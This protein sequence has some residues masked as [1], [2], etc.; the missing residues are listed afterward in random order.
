[1]PLEELP[2]YVNDVISIKKKTKIRVKL[3]LE[4]DF[5][6]DDMS[7]FNILKHYAFDYFI[8]SVHFIGEWGFDQ[9]DY[10]SEFGRMGVDKAYIKYCELIGRM[11]D[12]CLFDIVGHLDLPKKFGHFPGKKVLPHFDRA[13]R[14]VKSANMAVE[15]NTSGL[16]RKAKEMYPSPDILKL[17]YQHDIP[18]TLGSDSH[19]PGEV[20]R[21]F[22]EAKALLRKVGYHSLVSFTNHRHTKFRIS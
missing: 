11:A 9:D 19:K 2:H 16:D 8:G 17:C 14:F 10:V 15:I 5:I 7:A 20:G 18:L 12:T 4:V 13:L 22:A 3:G 6:P 1:M 21:H